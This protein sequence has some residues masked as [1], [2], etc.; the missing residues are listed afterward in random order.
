[1]PI[2]GSWPFICI[3]VVGE[4]V[5]ERGGEAKEEGEKASS[6]R[7]GLPPTNHLLLEQRPV[8]WVH[9]HFF[10]M[11]HINWLKDLGCRANR[12]DILITAN[13]FN[14][15]IADTND[16]ILQPLSLKP[17]L[18]S[19]LIRTIILE[20]QYIILE[21][22]FSLLFDWNYYPWNLMLLW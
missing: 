22:M 21:A 17:C 15:D 11:A 6:P 20:A 3:L 7:E 12:K 13:C 9:L 2:S 1:M 16:R 4:D 18:R 10:T 14:G 5:P 8:H 19:Y